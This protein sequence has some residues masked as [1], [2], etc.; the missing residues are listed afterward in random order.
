[1]DGTRQHADAR[2]GDRWRFWLRRYGPA[3]LACLVTMLAA[4]TLAAR[5]TTS[6][7]LLAASAIAGA[8][9]GFYGVLVVVVGREQ[10]GVV[11][12]DQHRAPARGRV[13]G[14]GAPR[15]VPVATGADDVGRRAPRRAGLGS[16]GRQD[17]R[18]R[19]LLRRVGRRLP[20]HGGHRAPRASV[21]DISYMRY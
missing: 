3:E 13:R 5:L 10:R 1:M 6:P 15:H 12:R 19:P 17:R 11:P 8:T 16:A 4:S 18:R 7:L 21:I 20:G 2:P 9:V 14:R